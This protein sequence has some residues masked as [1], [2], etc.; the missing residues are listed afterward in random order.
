GPLGPGAGGRRGGWVR[1]ARAAPRQARVVSAAVGTS[2][3]S[4]IAG[5]P[6][7]A[8][9]PVLRR[10]GGGHA[11]S[12]AVYDGVPG[13]PGARPA[14]DGR[15]RR[16][17]RVVYWRTRQKTSSIHSAPGGSILSAP[18]CG[19]RTPGAD[20]ARSWPG[21]GPTGRES[22]EPT[23]SAVRCA[24]A[25]GRAAGCTHRWVT[26]NTVTSMISAMPVRWRR[27]SQEAEG[28]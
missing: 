2:Y 21:G 17:G 26:R 16:P 14:P 1:R 15:V 22:R 12:D 18:S 25:R 9:G 19:D 27:G 20:V 10:T 7:P 6:R 24:R 4:P 28:R 11:G 23:L 8:A 13:A 3:R 5:R